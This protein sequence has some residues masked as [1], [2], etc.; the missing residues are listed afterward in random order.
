M[1]QA[2][3]LRN[4][5]ALKAA[6]NTPEWKALCGKIAH[7][8][9]F[10][11]WFGPASHMAGDDWPALVHKLLAPFN[12]AIH[13]LE[14]NAPLA[15]LIAPTWEAV[16]AHTDRWAAEISSNNQHRLNFSPS[17][18]QRAVRARFM[19]HVRMSPIIG[20]AAILN[21]QYCVK[22]EALD[23]YVC[24]AKRWEKLF[25][26]K[27]M[28]A[29]EDDFVRVAVARGYD[30]DDAR[31]EWSQF[32]FGR[33]CPEWNSEIAI[34]TKDAVDVGKWLFDSSG[35][36]CAPASPQSHRARLRVWA[37]MAKPETGDNAHDGWPILSEIAR[38]AL[39][40]HASACAAERNWS[41]WKR[42][43]KAERASMTLEHFKQRML[44]A[45]FYNGR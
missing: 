16:L 6:V 34:N 40:A 32:I 33:T 22:D 1:M 44:V 27:A 8:N 19:K 23:D 36:A 39:T 5:E 12:N 9:D 10:N 35:K 31:S 42:L 3:F 14:A 24:D 37:R 7:G 4:G 43:C 25:G 26:S 21:P 20:I 30:A 41:A 18:V 11:S 17:K 28:R 13:T 38:R 29:I 15:S 45:E 2:V